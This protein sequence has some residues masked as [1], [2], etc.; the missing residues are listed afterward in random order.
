MVGWFGVRCLR[1]D[2]KYIQAK[3]LDVQDKI[4]QEI[5]GLN[6]SKTAEAPF[7]TFNHPD[8][9]RPT[10]V[11]HAL[12]ASSVEFAS[13][14]ASSLDFGNGQHEISLEVPES[15]QEFPLVDA[16][17]DLQPRDKS[18][19]QNFYTEAAK[20]KIEQTHNVMLVADEGQ[21]V[22][23]MGGSDAGVI[24]LVKAKLSTLLHDFEVRNHES[25]SI[26]TH[27]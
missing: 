12:D 27:S 24:C 7:E 8:V 11:P 15:L 2:A 20:K 4:E 16:W 6:P 14:T 22:I 19:H 21:K 26:T 9:E 3:F 25:Q 23:L 17:L 10:P 1:S 18:F 5:R 13:D